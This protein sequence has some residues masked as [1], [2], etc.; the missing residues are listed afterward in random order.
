MS[1]SLRTSR[2]RALLLV[3]ALVIAQWVLA[4]HQAQLEAHAPGEVCE[5]CL[6]HAPLAGALP[7]KAAAVPPPPAGAAAARGRHAR[8]RGR[9]ASRAG[10]ACPDR[11]SR[12]SEAAKARP[13]CGRI[14][15]LAGRAPAL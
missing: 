2:L 12:S 14:G 10:R 7:A 4:Q 9:G 8:A 3:G 6:T 13:R 1:F 5:W 15:R 11:L